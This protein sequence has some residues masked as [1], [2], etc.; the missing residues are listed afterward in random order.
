[1][2]H[3]KAESD[4]DFLQNQHSHQHEIREQETVLC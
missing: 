1:M 4:E 2:I 3:P